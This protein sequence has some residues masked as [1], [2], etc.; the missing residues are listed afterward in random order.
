MNARSDQIKGHLEESLGIVTDDAA[1]QAKG[2]ADRQAGE[3]AERADW[4][5]ARLPTPSAGTEPIDYAVEQFTDSLHLTVAAT[6]AAPE[7]DPGARSRTR[8]AAPDKR[9]P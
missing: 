1:L 2:R 5:K 8:R 6:P 3:A 4:A 9:H 7:P